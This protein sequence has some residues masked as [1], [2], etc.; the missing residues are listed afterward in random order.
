[1]KN[2]C[3]AL[4]VC[5]ITLGVAHAAPIFGTYDNIITEPQTWST[6]PNSPS[7]L[8]DTRE[9]GTQWDNQFGFVFANNWT[10]AYT[11]WDIQWWFDSGWV[12]LSNMPD[13]P[14]Y[15]SSDPESRYAYYGTI[16][17]FNFSADYSEY[18]MPDP[19]WANGNEI[20]GHADLAA[21]V[22][23]LFEE[24]GD[25]FYATFELSYSGVPTPTWCGNPWYSSPSWTYFSGYYGPLDNASLTIESAVV[26][27]P[28]SMTLLG[29]GVAALAFKAARK[30][31][32][33]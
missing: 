9:I 23:A 30:R 21:Q 15:S 3:M 27:E 26:P 2:I 17:D 33:S 6:S 7:G 18:Y 4:A 32:R 25:P 8:P 1:M 31:S 14:W 24:N 10:G 20:A 13:D 12:Y 22:T 28:A 19:D 5:L 11:Q 16:V 29:L